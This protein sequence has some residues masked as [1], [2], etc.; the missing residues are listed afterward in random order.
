MADLRAGL[1][2]AGIVLLLIGVV[3]VEYPL[4][5]Q[6]IPVNNKGASSI[7]AVQVNSPL[8]SQ[9]FEVSWSAS[10]VGTMQYGVCAQIPNAPTGLVG[11][12]SQ[13][14]SGSGTSGTFSFS[15]SNGQFVVLFFNG[16]GGTAS[17]KTTIPT[18]GVLVIVI[19]VILLLAGA[20]LRS[21]PKVQAAQSGPTPP[22]PPDQTATPPASK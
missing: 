6:A 9:H 20:A 7:E 4:E 14:G 19:G 3:L 15:A 21:Q 1:L 22:V 2:V 12:C 17:A 11:N 10:A 8:M 16:S 5:P 13:T 18:A